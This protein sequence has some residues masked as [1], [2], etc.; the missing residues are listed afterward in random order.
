MTRSPWA[1][2]YARR[3]NEY[4][5]GTAPSPFAVAV[6]P[7]VVPGAVVLDLGCGEGRDSVFFAAG[8]ARVIGVDLSRAGLRKAE[9]L[10][11]TRRVTVQWVA[12]DLAHLTL[13][14]PFDLVYSCGAM[15]YVPRRARERLLIRL[16]G[17]TR[18]GGHHAHLVFTDRLIYVEKG[19]RI[20]YFCPGELRALYPDWQ[21]LECSE[22]VIT[23]QEDGTPHRHS[24]ERL[25][26]RAPA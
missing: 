10:A 22:D 15:H 21:V 12:A 17:L 1:R 26:V 9:R 13:P 18:P 2:E 16:Q 11:R 20:D 5:W 7:H 6:A 24:V 8:G 3:P 23:C 14:G 25:V 19:E 4:V